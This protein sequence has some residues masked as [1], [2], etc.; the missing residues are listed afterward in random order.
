VILNNQRF[1]IIVPSLK[2]RGMINEST[3]NNYSCVY[4][5]NCYVRNPGLIY[6]YNCYVRN[7]GLVYNYNCYVRNPCLVYNYYCYVRNRGHSC[8][9]DLDFQHNM[10][11]YFCVQFLEV[12]DGCDVGIGGHVDYH[13]IELV[14]ML[15]IT[16]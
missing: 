3:M 2:R 4:N 15:T 11:W 5:Y 1:N 8:I 6:N 16:V 14:D 12:R 13:C 7:P 9:Q 10:P